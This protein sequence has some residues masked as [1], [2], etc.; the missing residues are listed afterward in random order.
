MYKGAHVGHFR[1]CPRGLLEGVNRTQK[2]EAVVILRC[3]RTEERVNDHLEWRY[4]CPSQGERLLDIVE[5]VRRKVNLQRNY[6]S[7]PYEKQSD[8]NICHIQRI[9]LPDHHNSS[10]QVRVF[11]LP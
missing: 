7:A 6:L 5:G 4:I 3:P 10:D 1:S 2:K 11:L 9:A 8:L